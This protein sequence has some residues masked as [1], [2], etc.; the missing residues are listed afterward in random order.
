MRREPTRLHPAASRFSTVLTEDA[1][2]LTNRACTPFQFLP[3]STLAN[4][5]SLFR[6]GGFIFNAIRI[7]RQFP[8]LTPSSSAGILN[9]IA[10]IRVCGIGLAVEGGTNL[11]NL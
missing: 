7:L 8:V 3:A 4:V 10:Q 11:R 5:S 2:M 9:P 1:A 6:G